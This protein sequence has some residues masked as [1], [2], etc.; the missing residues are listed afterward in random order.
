M[1]NHTTTNMDT[2][3]SRTRDFDEDI[4]VQ[5]V[6]LEY[7]DV[8]V[9][10]VSWKDSLIYSELRAKN[11]DSIK[12]YEVVD[13]SNLPK[14]P[15]VIDY[16]GSPAGEIVIWNINEKNKSCMIGSEETR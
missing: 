11:E 4:S 1:T 15:L 3:M 9:R 10:S 6:F 7:K 2:N 13:N 14:I 12:S 5:S 8:V 16:K